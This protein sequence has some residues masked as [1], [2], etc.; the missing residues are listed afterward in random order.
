MKDVSEARQR[1]LALQRRAVKFSTGINIACPRHF[2]SVPS[3]TIWR[4]LVRA[5]D[6]VSNNLVEADTASSPADF[7]HKIRLTLRETRE[8]GSAWKSSGWRL[9]TPPIGSRNSNPKPVSYAQSSQLLRH[10]W[11]AASNAKKVPANH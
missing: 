11:R 2:T 4:Q 5:A 6:S 9:W 3:E 7:L 8:R 10:G 1:T